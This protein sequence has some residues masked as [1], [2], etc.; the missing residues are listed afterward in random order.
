LH[1]E[2]DLPERYR[3]L[4]RENTLELC[5]VRFEI[6]LA[7]LESGQAIAK[8]NVNRTAAVYKDSLEPDTVDAGIEDEGK[9]ARFR[10][11]GPPVFTVEGDFSVR[12]GWEPRIGDEVIGISNAHAISFEQF[13]LVFGL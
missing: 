9:P 4:S 8:Q 11:Y 13:A 7:Q 10:N 12:P 6:S 2:H 5:L 1:G 3:A